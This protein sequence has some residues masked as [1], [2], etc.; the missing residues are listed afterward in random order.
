M[1]HK[2][3]IHSSVSTTGLFPFLLFQ[4][5]LDH[6]PGTGLGPNFPIPANTFLHTDRGNVCPNFAAFLPYKLGNL[7][8]LSVISYPQ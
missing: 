8:L 7:L 1:D 5:V 2:N 6:A 4:C 3:W